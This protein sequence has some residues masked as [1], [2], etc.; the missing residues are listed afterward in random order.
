MHAKHCANV[1]MNEHDID[2]QVYRDGYLCL[3]EFQQILFR[4]HSHR[5]WTRS[6]ACRWFTDTSNDSAA[7]EYWI[8]F[9][10]NNLS[11]RRRKCWNSKRNRSPVAVAWNETSIT[12]WRSTWTNYSAY[13]LFI[14]VSTLSTHAAT[15][16]NWHKPHRITATKFETYSFEEWTHI[17]R[18]IDNKWP[19]SII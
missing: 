18:S 15:C 13:K 1:M 10:V 2:S 9:P 7:C 16:I 17:R 11:H 8:E 5:M 3:I 12:T 6:S 14:L 4:M 19:D